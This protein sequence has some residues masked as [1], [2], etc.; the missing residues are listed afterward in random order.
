MTIVG[1]QVAHLHPFS[2]CA[3][4]CIRFFGKAQVRVLVHQYTWY[5]LVNKKCEVVVLK[6]PIEVTHLVQRTQI[7][8]HFLS[9]QPWDDQDTFGADDIEEVYG[10]RIALLQAVNENTTIDTNAHTQ[11]RKYRAESGAAAR[12]LRL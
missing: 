10:S 1:Y 3:D 9:D 7:A 12:R 2:K 11:P 5:R 6:Q 4:K 8:R